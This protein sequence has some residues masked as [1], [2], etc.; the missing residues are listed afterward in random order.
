MAEI[1]KTENELETVPRVVVDAY[2]V[3]SR[4]VTHCE[5]DDGSKVSATI[6][7]EGG[8]AVVRRVTLEADIVNSTTFRAVPLRKV[9]AAG[10]EQAMLRVEVAPDGTARTV[11][12]DERHRAEA[13]ATIAKIVGYLDVKVVEVT[14]ATVSPRASVPTPRVSGT[15]GQS[16]P[17]G[18]RRS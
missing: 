9:V 2:T 15:K 17:R 3:P 18:K 1:T 8:R 7:V 13:D 10:M 6:E 14:P 16:K 11:E 5:L 4:F 12:V